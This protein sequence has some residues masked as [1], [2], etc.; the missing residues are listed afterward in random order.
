M[1]SVAWVVATTLGFILGG[2]A[3]HSPGASAVGGAYF[4]WDVSAA[5]FGAILGGIVGAIT[6]ALQNIALGAR[7]L[8]V[9]VAMV[10]AIAAAHA[11]ADGA[12]NAWGVHAV[13]ALSAIVAALAMAWACGTRAPLA[14]AAWA[15]AWWL[16]WEIG[17]ALAGALGLSFGSTP[18]IWAQE[19]LVI[20]GLLGIVFGAATSPAMRRILRT[21]RAL[22]SVG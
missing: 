7:N 12:P 15:L 11:L 10:V 3:L 2:A 8:R 22:S 19:H 16:G 20:A 6:G 18:E 17:V 1:R 13:A 21:E 14:L 4:V 9:I 5:I